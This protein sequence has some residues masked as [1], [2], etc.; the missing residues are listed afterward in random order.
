L[1]EQDTNEEKDNE[2]EVLKDL[3]I[4]IMKNHLKMIF[5]LSIKRNGALSGYDLLQRTQDKYQVNLSPG[6]VYTQLYS[7]ERKNLLKA[8]IDPS[9]KRVY[10][11]TSQGI[12]ATDII[13]SS[14]H[15]IEKMFALLFE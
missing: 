13:L 14:R 8:Q 3:G 7:L 5:L 4:E 2:N 15:Q 6:T 10:S 9:G 11:L 12:K 1:S